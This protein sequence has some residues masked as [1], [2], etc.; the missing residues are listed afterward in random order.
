MSLIQWAFVLFLL[1][2]SLDER[3]YMPIPGS[4]SDSEEG[5]VD[6]QGILLL[7]LVVFNFPVTFSNIVW[8]DIVI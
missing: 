5:Y 4:A 8:N 3:D 2:Y 7:K 1:R 6:L